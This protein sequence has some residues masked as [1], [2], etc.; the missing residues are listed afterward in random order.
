[1][2]P[3]TAL[4]KDIVDIVAPGQALTSEIAATVGFGLTVIV[5]VEVTDV[6][7]VLVTFLL[8]NVVEVSVGGS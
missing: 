8:Y 3:T 1:M 2:D 4:L 7:H 6:P 5:I